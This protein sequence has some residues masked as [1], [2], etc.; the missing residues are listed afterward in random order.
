MN[1]TSQLEIFYDRYGHYNDGSD[2]EDGVEF[3]LDR[4]QREY[5]GPTSKEEVCFNNKYYST[6][7]FIIFTYD[8]ST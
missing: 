3:V 1:A 2:S 8:I 5:L 7:V 4:N 6:F